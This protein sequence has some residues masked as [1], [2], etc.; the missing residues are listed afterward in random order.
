[1]TVKE[2]STGV[3]NLPYPDSFVKIGVYFAMS[4]IIMVLDFAIEHS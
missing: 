4:N 1:M 3:T 2:E